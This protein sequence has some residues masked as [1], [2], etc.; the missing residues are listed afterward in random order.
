MEILNHTKRVLDSPFSNFFP[1][2]YC[3]KPTKSHTDTSFS[4]SVEN[5]IVTS[6]FS[7]VACC[8]VCKTKKWL[9]P[10]LP[11]LLLTPIP[12]YSELTSPYHSQGETIFTGLL[13]LMFFGAIG[14]GL[15]K[16]LYERR[17]QKWFKE[18]TSD[19]H[20]K[21]DIAPFRRLLLFIESPPRVPTRFVSVAILLLLAIVALILHDKYFFSWILS[22]L[23][24]IG[25]GLLL[26]VGATFLIFSLSVTRAERLFESWFPPGSTLRD[27][28]TAAV[29]QLIGECEDIRILGSYLRNKG[30]IS[31]EQYRIAQER[32]S[33]IRQ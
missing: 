14:T 21:D 3:G 10:L 16:V 19:N 7:N 32:C 28:A 6:S 18:F 31:L 15:H 33:E 5:S 12:M 25:L 27:R 13:Y 20:N 8:N 4:T 9:I 26:G 17:T 24:C 1:C 22:I 29:L 23:I 30:E 11:V 2:A